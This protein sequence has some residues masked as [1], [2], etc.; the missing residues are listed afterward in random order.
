V[1]KKKL[2]NVDMRSTF[3]ILFFTFCRLGFVFADNNPTDSLKSVLPLLSGA[4]KLNALISLSGA[5][6][7]T[8]P[9]EA[10][11]YADE[12]IAIA[13][14][15]RDIPS[16]YKALKAR[17]LANNQAGFVTQSMADLQEGLDYY[18]RVRD[19][20]AIATAYNDLG[21][22]YQSQALYER[23]LEQYKTSL[24]LLSLQQNKQGMAASLSILGALFMQS[25]NNDEA[26]DYYQQAIEI[27]EAEAMEAEKA[28]IIARAGEIF[29]RKNEFDQ[30]LEYLNRALKINQSLGQQVQRAANLGNI[31]MVYL[32]KL[33][34]RRAI[35]FF[36][37][38]LNIQLKTGDQEGF[39]QSHYHLGMAKRKLKLYSEALEHFNLSVEAS[40][41]TRN[42]D[43]TIRSLSQKAG[44]YSLMGQYQ[45]AYENLNKARVLSDSL[46]SIRQSEL[47]EDLKM[48]Y[49]TEKYMIENRNLKLT[50]QK[51]EI[52]IQ[53]QQT[54]LILILSIGLLIFL[55]V[56][57]FM[58]K[59]RSADKLS[60]V[61]IEQKL[62]RS[63]MNPHFI[64]NSL[65][66]I[67]SSVMKKTTKESVNLI[68]SMASLMRLILDNSTHEFIE[69]DKEIQTL[70]YYLELQQQ[71]FAGQ[72]EWLLDIE[73]ELQEGEFYIPPMLAQ[74]FIENAIEH[75]FSGIQHQGMI[76][77]RFKALKGS[78]LCEIHDNGIGYNEGLK[79]KKDPQ[80]RSYGI[81]IT[82]Q[83][84]A[85]LQ[86]KYG[87][88]A[89]LEI[90]D[91]SGDTDRGT[92]VKLIIPI[93]YDY[94]EN[95]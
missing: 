79:H 49:E 41:S 77:I 90:I 62:L 71:R 7:V 66:L 25:G 61:E 63:Q 31:G 26:L 28:V 17:A 42:N 20:A 50:N 68:S 59:R 46:F 48:R 12:A 14:E 67:Q 34:F 47:A 92:L 21:L 33:N 10:L 4:E 27:Y 95:G 30:A 60:T 13:R 24:D 51:N 53:Q 45:P 58:Q 87:M 83:R 15:I 80:H 82:R 69:F 94:T 81:D 40:E 86:K 44:I 5:T 8:N 39:A 23:A 74:P 18:V 75:G 93:Q 16:R 37:Q 43:L 19:T 88:N 52:I 72:F 29:I 70:K 57:L 54:V 38:A 2:L 22:L 56:I 35:N 11:A 1:L 64:F 73:E 65:S 55:T 3:L 6:L 36:N 9:Q 85:V 84:I 32:Q 89:S 78:I 76:H 91:R